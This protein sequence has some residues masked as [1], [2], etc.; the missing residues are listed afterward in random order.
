ML[1]VHL[2]FALVVALV[3]TAILAAIGR[4]GYER[5]NWLT[6]VILFGILFLAS[7]AGGIWLHPVGPTVWGAAWMPFVAVGFMVALLVA[8]VSAH[9]RRRT[10]RD[11][12][13]ALEAEEVVGT[14]VTA[15]LWIFAVCLVAA[16]TLHYAYLDERHL[17]GERRGHDAAPPSM[18]HRT[19]D[20]PLR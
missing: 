20:Q 5:G 8:A 4:G 2:L 14:T 1:G 16:I 11:A 3:F 15:F 6:A 7:W 17:A 10:P 12:Q 13:E 18:A 19:A 9:H